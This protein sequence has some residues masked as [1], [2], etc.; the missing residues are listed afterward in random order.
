M[1]R[2]RPPS[3]RFSI[4]KCVSACAAICG[5]CVMHSTWNADPSVR[6]FRATTSATRPPMPASTSSKI[7]PGADALG[8]RSAASLKPCREV[9]V[10]VLMREHDARQLAAGDDPR[11]RA[12]VLA[13]VRR[14]EELGRVD[15]AG[16]PGRVRDRRRRSAPRIGCAPS[17]APRAALRA[18]ARASWRRGAAPSTAPARRRE[19]RRA[20][21]RAPRSSS[22]IRSSP[23][24]RSVSS[25][26]SAS[27]RATTSASAGPYFRF[28]R[29]SSARR[30]SSCWS[31]AGD[32][33]MP[34]A[35][36]RR[37]A[38]EVLELRL[39][40]VA[41]V[42]IRLELRIERRQLRRRAARRRR[43][44]PES[45]R[46]FRTGRRSFPA[47]S[48]STRS[49]LASTWRSAASST[50]SPGSP[51]RIGFRPRPIQLAELKG[52]QVLP[53]VPIPGGARVSARAPP[54]TRASRRTR[55]RSARA[56]NRA[57]RT[58][59]G[60]R[61]AWTGRAASGARAGRGARSGGTTAPSRRRRWRARR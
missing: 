37:N 32:A 36:L 16:A 18:A 27:R 8:G 15:A 4:S 19:R 55:P 11:Q 50:S 31:R 28:R 29:S 7:R 25:R 53:R 48:R 1:V 21:R 35:Y 2:V 33:S 12:E 44:P 47:Q 26:R 60:R 54:A 46:R 43:A 24:S 30:S 41:G 6:S 20:R 13:G 52:D 22:A 9:A 23:R 56:A 14:D 39:D 59:R 5:R 17:P 40:P 3:T 42:E 38:G 34:A 49:A 57:R 61:D 45:R 58:C 10:S 51:A